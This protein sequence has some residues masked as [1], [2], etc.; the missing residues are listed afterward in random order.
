M[1]YFLIAGEASG[2]LHGSHL[3]KEL[4]ARDAEAEFRFFGGDFMAKAAG[5][6]AIIHYK[7]LAYMGVVQVAMH[8]HII[9]KGMRTCKAAI[10]EWHP[11]SVIL[12][13][14]PGFNLSIAEFVHK[15]GICPVFYYISPKI[16]AW[17]EGR[18]KRIKRDVDHLFSIL[19]FELD[20]YEGK[21]HY[22]ITYVGNPTLDEVAEFKR[23]EVDHQASLPDAL[24]IIA[25]LPGSRTAEITANLPLMLE[26]AKPYAADG[27]KLVVAG[28]PSQPRA[29]YENIFAKVGMPAPELIFGETFS[30]LSQATAAL[31]TSGTATLETALFRVPQVVCFHIKGGRIINWGRPYVLKVPYI[32]L[33]NLICQR[34]IIPELIAA[35]THPKIIREHL[36][37]ILPGGTS[38]DQQ[39]ADYEELYAKLGEPGA[40]EKCAEEIIRRSGK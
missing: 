12:I 4:R 23:R 22:P 31:V 3:I 38:R 8:L 39:L 17:K 9:L 26:A 21:H 32:S 29:L 20:F 14:Y 24:P 19:P 36:A 16:W 27:Y 25:I 35:D 7:S 40:P 15:A 1:K 11:D 18:I 28:A 2:D 37:R 34:E 5:C 10:R 33:P 6:E 30:L 13:D